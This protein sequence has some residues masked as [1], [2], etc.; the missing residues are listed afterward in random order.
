MT[1]W[2]VPATVVRVVDGDTVVLDL[3]LGWH[4][5]LRAGVRVYGVDAPELATEEGKRAAEWVRSWLPVGAPVTFRSRVL[6]KYGRP[7]GRVVLGDG[8]DLGVLLVDAGM[9]KPYFGG[10]R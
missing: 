5:T 10:K 8:R 9:A 6:D 3:D 7:L 4:I 1:E 2:V